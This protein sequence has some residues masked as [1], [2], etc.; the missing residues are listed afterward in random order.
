MRA[1]IH[2]IYDKI[3]K[4]IFS[5]SN[6]AI[7]CLINGLFGTSY[8]SDSTVEFL[9]TEYTTLNLTGKFA[10]VYLV[11]GG[12]YHYHLEAQTDY[13]EHIIVRVF[14][15]GFYHAIGTADNDMELTFPEPVVIYLKGENIPET[16]TI[17]IH[18]GT[19]G[20][21]VYQVQNFILSKQSLEELNQ[22]KLIVQKYLRLN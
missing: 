14:E 18:F 6:A 11:I 13:N 2:Q 16:S 8:P 20:D 12:L 21:F 7:I 3:F 15:Y 10:D 22:K 17:T 9:R 19:Q 5:L 1:E 4:R